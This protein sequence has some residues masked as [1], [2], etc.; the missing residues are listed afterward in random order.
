VTDRV[1]LDATTALE[2]DKPCFGEQCRGCKDFFCCP[3]HFPV[4]CWD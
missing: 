3:E 1:D 2:T 4:G